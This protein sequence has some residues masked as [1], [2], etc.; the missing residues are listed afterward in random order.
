MRHR[1]CV[2]VLCGAAMIV[3][4]A[5]QA[6][7]V[8][9][10]LGSLAPA[11]SLRDASL[12]DMAA[13]WTHASHGRAEVRVM[14]VAEDEPALVRKLRAGSIDATALTTAGLG[15]VDPAFNVFAI[16]LFFDSDA[17]L[18]FVQDQLKPLLKSRLEANGLT[19]LQ[20]SSTGW[21]EL[22]STR[23]VQTLADVK[24]LKVAAFTGDEA[25]DA[26]YGANGF[27]LVPTVIA[28][29]VIRLRSGAIDAV[30]TTPWYAVLFNWYHDAPKLIDVHLV[31]LAT[32]VVITRSVWTRAAGADA[33]ALLDVAA[34]EETRLR[35]EG[36][37]QDQQSVVAMKARGL[38]VIAIDAVRAAE[39][40]AEAQKFAAS[41]RGTLVP[42]D[43]YDA[44]LK[45]RA[46]FRQRSSIHD[47]PS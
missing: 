25:L 5:A 30:P 31:P 12:R 6:P 28:D 35:V 34:H 3:I 46:M 33:A 43:V 17:E 16:P 14:R 10:R 23:P 8:V 20:L 44:A 19:L 22:F 2:A 21:V 4:P 26:A 7:P 32:A 40:R 36:A 29:V 1:L 47:R 39:W 45:A 13:A 41:A 11:N 38:A 18:A 27:H 42:A 37:A 9:I 24:A 15:A